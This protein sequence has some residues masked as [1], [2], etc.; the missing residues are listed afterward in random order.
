VGA[1]TTTTETKPSDFPSQLRQ[2]LQSN[3]Q[4]LEKHTIRT[5]ARTT[6]TCP[7]CGRLEVWFSQVQLRGA[8]E[9]STTFFNCECGFRYASEPPPEEEQPLTCPPSRWSA[10]N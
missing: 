9:G 8:D 5:E 1:K 6:E 3:V 10:N 2:K 4:T 7:K